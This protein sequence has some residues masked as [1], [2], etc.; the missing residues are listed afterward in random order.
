M[1]WKHP[2]AAVVPCFNEA[3][4]INTIIAG[5]QKHLP[6]IIVVDDGSTGQ[7]VREAYSPN[8]WLPE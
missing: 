4:H 3:A 8:C 2:C 5:V 6:K 1:D 7:L